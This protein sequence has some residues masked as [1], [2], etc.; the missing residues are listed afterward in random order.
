MKEPFSF[1]FVADQLCVNWNR[2]LVHL[3]A[4]AAIIAQQDENLFLN[5][6]SGL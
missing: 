1:S 2:Q 3:L 4:L 6:L 5:D